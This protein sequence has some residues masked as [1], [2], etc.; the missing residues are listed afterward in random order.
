MTPFGHALRELRARHN[1]KL[2]DLARDLGVT[3]AYLSAL[4]H[5][6]RGRPTS[7][8]VLQVCARFGL[9]WDDAEALKRLARL[10]HPRVVIDTAGLSPQA[11]ELA[12]RLSQRIASLPPERLE[13]LLAVLKD[14]GREPDTDALASEA[15][16]PRDG[17][18][19]RG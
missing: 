19:A 16:S 1:V 18:A 8:L 11:T 5:G 7:G 17:E 2:G 6:H 3:A 15:S 14:E 9:I 13:R 12:N 4:E 10:S